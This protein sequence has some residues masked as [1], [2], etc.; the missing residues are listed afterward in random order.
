MKKAKTFKKKIVVTDE[1]STPPARAERLKQ[2]RNMA[3]LSREEMCEDDQIN[4]NTYKGWE[5]SRYGGLPL[6][7]AERVVERVAREGVWCT[8]EWLVYEIGRGAYVSTDFKN[9]QKDGKSEAT[10]P[11]KMKNQETPIFNE[12]L[13]FRKQFVDTI[14]CKILDDGL[15]PE[16][17]TGDFVA[18]VKH[19]N[20]AIDALLNQN[21]IVQ[22]VNG[23]ITVRHLR[24]GNAPNLYMLVCTNPNTSVPNPV[25]YDAQLS[26]AAPIL[27]HYKIY[28]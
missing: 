6:D 28:L 15:G 19:Y 3:N 4:I 7:G 20:Q 22:L 27:R 25:V 24:K 26:S 11:A 1:L 9:A 16:I 2:V 13:L 12:I 10:F 21:C 23:E 14:D 18:G 5:L 17:I 8:V